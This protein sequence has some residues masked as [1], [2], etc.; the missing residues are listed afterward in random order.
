MKS[1]G[2]IICLHFLFIN[3]IIISKKIFNEGEI[4]KINL[5]VYIKLKD[6][7]KILKYILL[8]MILIYK[9]LI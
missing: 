9:I 8:L 4:M 6:V 2:E 3:I 5:Y 1:V 7:E